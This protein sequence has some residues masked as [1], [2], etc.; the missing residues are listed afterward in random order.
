MR[1]FALL[2]LVLLFAVDASAA[3]APHS[4]DM[5]TEKC[6]GQNQTTVGMSECYTLAEK[7]WDRELNRVY[8]ELRD[9]LTTEDKDLLKKAQR[10]WITQRDEEFALIN[11]IHSQMQGSMWILVAASQRVDVVKGRT[12]ALQSYVNWLTEGEP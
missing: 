9:Q 4:I 11:A 6:L 1:P 8:N 7:A 10:A 12:L 3:D 5:T 2:M